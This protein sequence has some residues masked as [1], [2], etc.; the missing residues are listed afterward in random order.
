MKLKKYNIFTRRYFYPLCSEFQC[1][2]NYPS[3]AAENLPVAE[4]I[5]KSILTL[6]LYGSLEEEDIHKI[7]DVIALHAK[8][9]TYRLNVPS[10]CLSHQNI[11]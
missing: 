6:P 2:R 8:R 3:S 7:S 1:Y 9:N 4:K 5:S 11:M 10:T